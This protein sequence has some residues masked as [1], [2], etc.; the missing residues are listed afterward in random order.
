MDWHG[1]PEATGVI[2]PQL[3]VY[4][5]EGVELTAGAFLNLGKEDTKFGN[6]TAG[7]SNVFL[8]ATATF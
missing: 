3:L 1:I 6:A 7:R 8:K 2:F 4:A 5:F